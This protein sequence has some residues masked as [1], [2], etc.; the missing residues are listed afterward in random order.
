[1]ATSFFQF[2]FKLIAVAWHKNLLFDRIVLDSRPCLAPCMD[3]KQTRN[4]SWREKSDVREVKRKE[5]MD[6][7]GLERAL[8]LPG[9]FKTDQP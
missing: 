3:L 7:Q 5:S 9:L 2:F 8:L 6:L 1:M 4:I